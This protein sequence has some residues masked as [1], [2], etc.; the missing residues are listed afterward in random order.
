MDVAKYEV[1]TPMTKTKSGNTTR[2]MPERNPNPKHE[3][4]IKIAAICQ[5]K[6]IPPLPVAR[7]THQPMAV[8]G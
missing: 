5:I 8:Q 7:L 1:A 4:K 3:A 2:V 6:G